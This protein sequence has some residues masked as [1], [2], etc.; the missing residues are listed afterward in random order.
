MQY[1][2]TSLVRYNGVDIQPGEIIDLNAV[3]AAVLLESGAAIPV[4]QPFAAI[5]NE[6]GNQ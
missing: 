5:L 2:T 3:D 1:K 6:L 4:D